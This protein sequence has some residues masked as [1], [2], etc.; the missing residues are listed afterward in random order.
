M[1]RDKLIGLSACILSGLAVVAAIAYM[2]T[3]AN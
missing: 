1:S 2:V 3:H